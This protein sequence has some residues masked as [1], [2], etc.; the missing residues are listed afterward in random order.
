ML[1]EKLNIS[2]GHLGKFERGERAISLGRLAQVCLILHVPIED[3]I[4]G[5]VIGE[6]DATPVVNALTQER[7]DTIYTLLKGQS[8]VVADLVVTL[9]RNVVDALNKPDID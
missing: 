6:R 5:C 8:D 1:A 9:A 3:V 4:A 7:I 2:I